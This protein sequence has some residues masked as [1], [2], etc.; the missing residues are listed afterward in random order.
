MVLWEMVDVKVEQRYE[1]RKAMDEEYEFR[2]MMNRNQTMEEYPYEQSQK[3]EV[4]V[5]DDC[6]KKKT[7]SYSKDYI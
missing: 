3:K 6:L 4:V 5:E 7:H 1:N 2:E